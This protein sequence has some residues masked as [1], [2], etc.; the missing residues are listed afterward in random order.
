MNITCPDCNGTGT[1]PETEETCLRCGG[2]GEIPAEGVH[3][4]T[5]AHAIEAYN[6]AIINEAKLDELDSKMDVLDA[7][8]AVIETKIDDLEV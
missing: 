8:L 6:K 5:Q 7:H 1:D 3:G 4:I 2:E